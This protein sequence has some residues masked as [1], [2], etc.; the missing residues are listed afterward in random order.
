MMRQHTLHTLA[1]LLAGAAAHAQDCPWE[2]FEVPPAFN[3]FH[4]LFD[5]DGV[6]GDDVWAVGRA[7]HFEFGDTSRWTYAVH[8]DG[9]GWTHVPTPNPDASG[10]WNDLSGVVMLGPDEA[11]A[12]GNYTH[13]DPG[14]ASQCL[15][16]RWD[17]SEWS[18]LDTPYIEGGSGLLE[19]EEIGGEV[20]AVGSRRNDAP[21]PATSQLAFSLRWTG[22]GWEEHPVPPLAELGRSFNYL[23]ALDGVSADDT[24]AVGSAQSRHF[25]DPFGPRA[26]MVHWDGN[27]WS[28][29][30]DDFGAT[31][32]SGFGDVE[33]IADDDV[34]AVGWTLNDQ[35]RTEPLIVHYDGSGWSRVALPEFAPGSAELRAVTARA[36]DDIYATGTW[37][38]GDGVPRDLILHYNGARW[39]QMDSAP[40]N[41][42]HQ[43][44]RG[45]T[46]LPNGDVW[47]VGQFYDLGLG[48]TIAIAERLRCD[49]GGCDADFN[50]DG[51]VNTLDVLAFLN[52]WSAN[53]PNADFNRDGTINTQDVLA[54]LNA[55]TAG[56]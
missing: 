26:Y 19:V 44:Y 40:V 43:W 16:M 29:V 7:Q 56:C 6:G 12:V 4:V 53:D 28:I 30:H 22:S 47:T 33:A 41:G 24:W 1:A 37:A 13:P 55:W 39:T 49:A 46:T 17:G 14:G 50:A 27:D 51:A 10:A 52:A 5:V 25:D 38:D 54:F 45:A 2:Q 31:D 23:V 48:S 20:W 3:S 36:A 11:I 9:T 32:P 18:L 42:T 35:F 21:P 8:F 34:W 15:A